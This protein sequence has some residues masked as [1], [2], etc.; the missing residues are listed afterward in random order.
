MGFRS[1]LVAALVAVLTGLCDPAIASPWAE[2]GDNQLRSDIEL[3][4]ASG[5]VDQ[6][7]IQW[8]L[9]WKSLRAGL[10]RGNLASQP[11]VVRA[12]A[13]RVLA[14]A[15]AATADGWAVGARLDAT[16]RN[17]LVYGFDGMGRGDGQAQVMLEDTSGIFSGRLA[18]G[19]ITQNFGA[20]ANKLMP[21]GSYLALRLGG[22]RVYAGYLDH[23]W[24]P[25]EISTLQLSNNARPMPQ[26][27]FERA[28]TAPSSW[29]LLNLLGPWQF[30]FFL[31]RLDGPQKQSNVDYDAAHL[32][33]RPLPGLEIG[34]G[35]T[36]EF[37]GQGHPCAPLRD[38]FT[39]ADL[40]NHPDNIN[41]EGSL[42]IKYGHLLGGI[43]V[44]V[45]AQM[46]NEDYS[47]FSRS[48]TS[49]LLGSSLFLPVGDN[50]LKL[51][52]EYA[53]SIA[54][55]MPF[56][57]GDNVYGFTYTNGQYP[58]GMRYRGRT[59]GFSLDSDST[60][61]SLQGSW[62]DH[63]GRFYEIS[64]HHATVSSAHSG[65][66]NI[67]TPLPVLLNMGEARI[68]LPWQGFRFDIAGRLQDD[69]PRPHHG[70]AAAIEIGLQAPL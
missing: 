26:I 34:L 52:L 3:L 66:A 50:P 68:S 24:G 32:T 49:H 25:G 12:A 42:E 62:S 13:Q 58:D 55:K 44:T 33:F 19:V 40:S 43:P 56:S 27:G 9:P 7:T 46:M 41:G 35:R 36:D 23:W 11:A 20:R 1:L 45:Y 47:F 59:L 6:L 10:E 22:V 69:Q 28:G 8:P 51:T 18:M 15:Q 57:F 2:V 17:A 61:L 64:L 54:T 48:G 29:P 39:N 70:F 67:L 37:C 65:A 53:N 4:A 21:D 5:V 14:R 31:G 30:E 38:Y 16:N 60:L 63:A